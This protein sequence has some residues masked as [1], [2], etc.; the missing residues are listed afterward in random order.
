MDLSNPSNWSLNYQQT[1][2]GSNLP[3]FLVPFSFNAQILAVHIYT[4]GDK[5]TWH[6]AGWMNQLVETN[7]VSSSSVW[8]A[9]SQRTLLGGNIVFLPNNFSSYQL[10]F[11]F[12]RWFPD[13]Y[14]TIWSY[15]G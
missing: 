2:S 12:P 14:L 3:D 10:Q 13:A 11:S 7:L 5:P 1:I 8:S 6:T 4:S 15:L 9:F